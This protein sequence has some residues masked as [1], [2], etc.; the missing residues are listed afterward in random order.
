MD[1]IEGNQGDD[2]WAMLRLG[3]VTASNVARIMPSKKTGKYQADREAYKF[4]IITERLTNIP[5][6]R[7]Q[8][9]AMRWGT[10]NEPYARQMYEAVTKSEVRQVAF[11]QHESMLNVGVSPDGLVGID[12]MIEI[13]CPHTKTHIETIISET[14]NPDYYDQ[15]TMQMGVGKRKWNDFTSFDPRLPEDMKIFIVRVPLDEAYWKFMEEEIKKF[16]S[17]IE[18]EVDK[19]LK[20]FPKYAEN[21]VAQWRGRNRLI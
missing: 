3:N 16:S 12:G 14:W 1:F 11:V 6:P 19:I 17:E 9:E 13:K 10:L 20:R 8:S 4:E 5:M 18:S 2:R 15:M 7:F 21:Y